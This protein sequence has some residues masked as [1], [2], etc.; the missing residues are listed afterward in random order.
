MTPAQT[1]ALHELLD[2]VN[3]WADEPELTAEDTAELL[4]GVATGIA[5]VCHVPYAALAGMLASTELA[6][7]VLCGNFEGMPS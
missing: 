4:I 5:A 2:L 1:R 3:D 7:V 6:E